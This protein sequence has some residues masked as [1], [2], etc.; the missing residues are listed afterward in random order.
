MGRQNQSEVARLRALIEL[1]YQTARIGLTGLAEGS[2]RHAFITHHMERVQQHYS[3]LSRLVGEERATGILIQ[4]SQA[5][6]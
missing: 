6:Q 2:T 4:A 5:I 3:K 1:E